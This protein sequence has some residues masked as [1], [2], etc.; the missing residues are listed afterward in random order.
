MQKTDPILPA[1]V[2]VLQH[3]G[4]QLIAKGT[5]ILWI[6]RHVKAGIAVFNRR[7]VGVECMAY[8]FY[9]RRKEQDTS[10]LYLPPEG[11]PFEIVIRQVAVRVSIRPKKGPIPWQV[12]YQI[13]SLKSRDQISKRG[14]SGA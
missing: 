8:C 9:G 1:G 3:N 7:Q 11:V 6:F 13:T 4:F 5:V 2:S 14:K 10:R 12:A